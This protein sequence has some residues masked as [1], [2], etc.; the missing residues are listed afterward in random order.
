MAH[1]IKAMELALGIESGIYEPQEA[2]AWADEY[3]WVN[4]YDD[5]VANVSLSGQKPKIELVSL[6]MKIGDFNDRVPAMRSVL[7][8]FAFEYENDESLAKTIVAYC[9]RFWIAQGYEVPDDMV[10]MAGLDDEYSLAVQGIYGTKHEALKR[11][12]LELEPFKKYAEQV[13]SEGTPLRG[14]PDL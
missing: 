7:G 2:V 10:F 8:R 5:D 13:D 6:L 14:T 4:A 9:E 3:L 12:H 11:L 1:H